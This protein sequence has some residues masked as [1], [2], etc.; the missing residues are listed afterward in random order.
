L[1]WRADLIPMMKNDDE[2][3]SAVGA[4]GMHTKIVFVVS[5]DKFRLH[6]NKLADYATKLQLNLQ[7]YQQKTAITTLLT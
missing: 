4:A 5:H 7:L 2:S 6:A 1:Q 3:N